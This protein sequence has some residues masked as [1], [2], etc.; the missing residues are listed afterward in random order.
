MHNEEDSADA[1]TAG[2]C[3]SEFHK[4]CSKLMLGRCFF[5]RVWMFLEIMF[6]NNEC[7]EIRREI[8][9]PQG[10]KDRLTGTTV[11]NMSGIFNP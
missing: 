4:L 10:L 1:E 9:R 8:T 7:N 6:N 3:K 5:L 2:R 11:S